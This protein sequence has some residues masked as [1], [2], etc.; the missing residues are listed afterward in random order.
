MQT[1]SCCGNGLIKNFGNF[2]DYLKL[3]G[4]IYPYVFL[5]EFEVCTLKS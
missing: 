1:F 5:H 2:L 4:N 3:F